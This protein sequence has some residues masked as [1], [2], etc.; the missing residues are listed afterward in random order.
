MLPS[1]YDL[2]TIEDL[3]RLRISPEME[4]GE[5]MANTRRY[6]AELRRLGCLK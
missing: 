5:I 3:E 1:W 4:S 6:V 2:D